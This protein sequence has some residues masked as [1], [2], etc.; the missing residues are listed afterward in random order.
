M[1]T[2]GNNIFAVDGIVRYYQEDSHSCTCKYKLR[3]NCSEIHLTADSARK[4]FVSFCAT[5]YDIDTS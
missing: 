1:A 5:A 2:C 3:Y 4:R